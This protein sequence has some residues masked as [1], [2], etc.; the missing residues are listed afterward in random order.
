MNKSRSY[1]L[2]DKGLQIGRWTVLRNR[3]SNFLL[4]AAPQTTF[5]DWKQMD[6]W[7][8][9]WKSQLTLADP[10]WT[11][12]SIRRNALELVECRA[13]FPWFPTSLV[14]SPETLTLEIS[15]K[16]QDTQIPGYFYRIWSAY[17]A[18][19]SSFLGQNISGN[20]NS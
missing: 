1:L 9:D 8:A 10:H 2:W 4:T 18:T 20:L 11:S 13:S 5:I 3:I 16:G 12:V 17:V 19:T 15:E 7:K 6:G 14:P